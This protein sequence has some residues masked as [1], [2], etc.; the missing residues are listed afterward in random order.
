[1]KR[2]TAFLCI[3]ILGINSFLYKYTAKA[4]E[5][6][7][8]KENPEEAQTEMLKAAEEVSD[9]PQIKGSMQILNAAEDGTGDAAVSGN[10]PYNGITDEEDG[11]LVSLLIPGKLDVI[12]NPWE[13]GGKP[14]V[15]SEDY[16]VKNCGSAAGFFA[17]TNLAC[18][19]QKEDVDVRPDNVGLHKGTEK[20]VWLEMELGNG[21]RITLTEEP[22][23]YEILLEPG[24]EFAF[25]FS[26]EANENAAEEWSGGDLS[27]TVTYAWNSV[28][29]E[30]EPETGDSMEV[31]AEE[32][33]AD[34]TEGIS[35]ET[36][37]KEDTAAETAEQE[38]A[39][40]TDVPDET[41]QAETETTE[42][43]ETETVGQERAA[44]ETDAFDETGQTETE[45][46]GQE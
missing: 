32:T 29:E 37:T 6:L 9:G 17:F 26:G 21:D 8:N 38:Q 41:G 14:Q 36:S 27:V 13:L 18:E 4:E 39:S 34:D 25:W 5:D 44:G 16:T 42:Q 10:T 30:A 11:G 7:A 46:A 31:P 28:E 2:T 22:V 3:F 19:P 35:V 40:E 24:E 12:L 45:A 1:M 43:A 33:D 23:R 20:N 15:Y